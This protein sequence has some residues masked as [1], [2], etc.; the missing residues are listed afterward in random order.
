MTT[1]NT[2]S[3]LPDPGG[4][5][6]PSDSELIC[7]CSNYALSGRYHS[8]ITPLRSPQSSA[9]LPS[10]SDEFHTQLVAS[11]TLT[12]FNVYMTLSFNQNGASSHCRNVP[13]V[14]PYWSNA[15]RPWTPQNWKSFSDGYK[16][17]LNRVGQAQVLA[18]LVRAPCVCRSTLF[19][20]IRLLCGRSSRDVSD[21]VHVFKQCLEVNPTVEQAFK[22]MTIS[23]Y[24]SEPAG[25]QRGVEIGSNWIVSCTTVTIESSPSY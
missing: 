4:G 6:C 2:T 13:C 22:G 1:I 24:P 17:E 8:S 5:K 9:M 14:V 25:V 7:S 16:R 21:L 20:A 3:F 18:E 12:G 15:P 11:R 10:K 19:A 23:I